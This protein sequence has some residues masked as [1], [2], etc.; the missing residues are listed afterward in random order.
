MSEHETDR[1]EA[2]P[3]ESMNDGPSKRKSSPIVWAL[4]AVV[5]SAG[6]LFAALVPLG[7]LD[8]LMPIIGPYIGA[9]PE[10]APVTRAAQQPK[11]LPAG[12][13]QADAVGMMAEQMES[14]ATFEQLMTDKVKSLKVIRV[15]KSPAE[16][17]IAVT[18]AFADGSSAPGT[19]TM[20]K[21]GANWY[22]SRLDGKRASAP[23]TGSAGTIGAPGPSQSA[24]ADS[25][26]SDG[27]YAKQSDV[28][29]AMTTAQVANQRLIQELLAGEYTDVVVSGPVKMGPDT[30][31]V[32]LEYRSA[33]GEVVKG[34][35]LHVR[36]T[37]AGDTYWFTTGF[38]VK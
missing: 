1:L 11:T 33:K 24:M 16:A 12:V 20:R 25:L 23:A 9:A 37:I 30:A 19:I 10:P 38:R 4:L 18:V 15:T 32:P 28:A 14:E 2:D 34:D 13:T 27:G 35:A 7:G 17:K 6:V 8:A 21:L 22:V 5:V 36:K 29:V 31:S 26:Q 3:S